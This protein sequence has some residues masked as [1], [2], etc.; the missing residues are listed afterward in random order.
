MYPANTMLLDSSEFVF[1]KT[2][3]VKSENVLN[4]KDKTN[5][6]LF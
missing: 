5:P 4:Q 1:T 6:K 3:V 2:E